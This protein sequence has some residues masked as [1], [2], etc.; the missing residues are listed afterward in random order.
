MIHDFKYLET[1]DYQIEIDVHKSFSKSMT[2][3]IRD[4]E[5]WKDCI[6]NQSAEFCKLQKLLEFA[7][8]YS[9]ELYVSRRENKY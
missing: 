4:R 6:Q 8:L 3:I 5:R 9:L 2:M 1:N 7:T